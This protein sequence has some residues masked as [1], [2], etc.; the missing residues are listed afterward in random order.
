MKSTNHLGESAKLRMGFRSDATI[1]GAAGEISLQEIPQDTDVY[2]I[3][4]AYFYLEHHK[5][6]PLALITGDRRF[7]IRAGSEKMGGVSKVVTFYDRS[8]AK[9][10]SI[11]DMCRLVDMYNCLGRDGFSS[12]AA[13]GFYHGCSSFF[14]AIQ[15]LISTGYKKIHTL[16]I[17]FPPP[18]LYTRLNGISGHPE[19]VYNIQLE[20]LAKMKRFLIDTNTEINCLDTDSNLKIFL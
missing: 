11:V 19:F 16:G 4:S 8:E 3:N 9:N 1:I 18:E 12:D 14:L 20:N 17:K 2:A 10:R 7:I 5:V 15:Y 13:A 6:A